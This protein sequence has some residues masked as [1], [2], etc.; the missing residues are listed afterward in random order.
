MEQLPQRIDSTF[1]YVLIA[2]KRAEQLVRGAR[3]KLEGAPAKPARL[4][5]RE[6]VA[7]LVD[8]DYG[9]P[10]APEPVA[11]PVEETPE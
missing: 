9:P 4:A 10:P 7:N 5:M 6:V 11:P 8:W 2:A 1:R 3:P